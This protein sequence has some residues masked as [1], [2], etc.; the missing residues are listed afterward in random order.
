M[1][2]GSRMLK[3]FTYST[4]PIRISLQLLQDSA[5]DFDALIRD[6]CAGCFQRGTDAHFTKGNGTTQPEGPI[7]GTPVGR[8]AAGQ[9]TS[10]TWDDLTELEHSADPA[11]RIGARYMFHDSV[12]NTLKKLK[13]GQGRPLWS[14]GVA[15]GAPDTINGYGY[16]INQDMPVMAAG[17]K[18]IAFGNFKNYVVRDVL[19]LQMVR[20]GSS[21]CTRTKAVGVS[22]SPP[23][24][25]PM[26][27][28]LI[29]GPGFDIEEPHWEA[30]I[31]ARTAG[32]HVRLRDIATNCSDIAGWVFQT[33]KRT[34]GFET[35]PPVSSW[36]PLRF[37]KPPFG[38][39]KA[40]YPIVPGEHGPQTASQGAG[41][42]WRPGGG[43]RG[44]DLM[45][46]SFYSERAIILCRLWA[47]ATSFRSMRRSSA[48]RPSM[49]LFSRGNMSSLLTPP[50]ATRASIS[51]TKSSITALAAIADLAITPSLIFLWSKKNTLGRRVPLQILG[52]AH[53]QPMGLEAYERL[54]ACRKSGNSIVQ[55]LRR[56][57]RMDV[58]LKNQAC[59]G[60]DHG[61]GNVLHQ[62]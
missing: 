41:R 32:E 10:V 43:W 45:S 8:T 39:V 59:H 15:V 4:L 51:R 1:T 9:T 28:E 13:D 17:A 2:F 44:G 5:F 24:G 12:L 26:T 60:I 29:A 6:A 57:V 7:L 3:S 34:F 36:W 40:H 50:A 33:V 21:L 27:F 58:T 25:G 52:A 22:P 48:G 62:A 19:N 38:N 55:Q 42:R 18:S 35:P 30:L 20:L 16:S 49:V 61:I 46:N 56:R 37:V 11:Y 54:S 47:T 53:P 31:P 14:P 23:I